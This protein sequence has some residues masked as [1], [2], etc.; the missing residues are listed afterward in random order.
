MSAVERYHGNTP[1]RSRENRLIGA[2]PAE[3]PDMGFIFEHNP[4]EGKKYRTEA[5][6]RAIFPKG[7]L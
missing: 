7:F 1:Q 6:R 5:K 4:A 2:L 3:I